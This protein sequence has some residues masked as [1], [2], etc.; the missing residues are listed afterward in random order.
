MQS[1]S[2]SQATPLPTSGTQTDT[3]G[4]AGSQCALVSQSLSL[5]QDAAHIGAVWVCPPL[6]YT[7]G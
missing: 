7:D 1:L 3:P 4:P 5:E 2:S 6:Q